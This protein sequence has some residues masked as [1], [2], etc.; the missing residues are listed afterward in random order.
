MAEPL[1]FIFTYTIKEGHRDDYEKH[2][3]ELMRFIEAS[4]PRLIAMDTYINEEGT[5]VS[6]VLIQPDSAAQ[7][8]HMQVAGD[9]L[10]E[11]YAFLDFSKLRV[12]IYGK[13]SDNLAARMGQ[14]ASSGVP[15]TIKG[16]HIG[17]FNRLPAL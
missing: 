3:P 11:G 7:E 2:V 15:V 13:L 5:E 12:E 10:N 8:F 17:G 16:R 1:I 9:K 6:T 4:E 14:M